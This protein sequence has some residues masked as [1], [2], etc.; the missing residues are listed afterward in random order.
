MSENKIDWSLVVEAAKDLEPMIKDD[1]N[2]T[3]NYSFVSIDEYYK[4]AAK[5]LLKKGLTW[6]VS[7]IHIQRHDDVWTWF[8]R[9]TL[10]DKAGNAEDV[11][12]IPVT[13]AYEGPQTTGKVFSYGEKIFMRT[14][15]KAVT[16]E[17]DADSSASK[18]GQP[19][20]RPKPAVDSEAPVFTQSYD[21]LIK[22]IL[23]SPTKAGLLKVLTENEPAIRWAKENDSDKFD[24]IRQ[25]RWTREKQIQEGESA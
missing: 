2:Q 19:A 5:A 15:L 9:F 25:A 6:T 7:T 8:L 10:R 1:R 24:A 13:H 3:D 14:L 18:K 20:S 22:K 12:D 23:E 21:S 17:P 11:A 4:F 16:G